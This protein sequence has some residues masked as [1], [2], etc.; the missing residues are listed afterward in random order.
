V[1]EIW[2]NVVCLD[3]KEKCV[4]DLW[5]I[6]EIPC[7]VPIGSCIHLPTP[8]EWEPICGAIYSQIDGYQVTGGILHCTAKP[9]G[10]VFDEHGVQELIAI[11]YK[12]TEPLE[13]RAA[14]DSILR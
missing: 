14:Y 12:E 1:G 13:L 5:V 2:C 8:K 3:D 7:I 4:A 9:L 6:I 11:G 10:M